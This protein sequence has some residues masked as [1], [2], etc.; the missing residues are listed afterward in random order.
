MKV[1]YKVI[2]Y[3]NAVKILPCLFACTA[4]T[5]TFGSRPVD[6]WNKCLALNSFIHLTALVHRI[7]FQSFVELTVTVDHGCCVQSGTVTMQDAVWV[8]KFL[9]S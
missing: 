2:C 9:K 6:E 7:S 8:V 5:S 3:C 4:S 1:M